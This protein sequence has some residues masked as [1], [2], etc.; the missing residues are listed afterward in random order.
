M[1]SLC[2][3]CLKCGSDRFRTR[4]TTLNALF[5]RAG[6]DRSGAAFQA[7]N[8]R[9]IH[10]EKNTFLRS[11]RGLRRRAPSCSTMRA[12]QSASRSIP[13][14]QIYPK[15]GWVEHDPREIASSQLGVITEV[16]V[17]SGV[18][19]EE[20]DSIGITNQRET[21]VVWNRGRALPLRMPS[22]GNAAVRPISSRK[23]ARGRVFASLFKQKRASFPMRTSRR[24]KIKW[25]LD[26]VP[27]AREAAEAGKLAFGTVDTWLIWQLTGGAVHATDVTNAS[28]TMLFNIHT[29]EWDEELL[30]LF[31]VPA[32]LLPEVRPSSGDFWNNGLRRGACWHSDSRR[33]GRSAGGLVRP[34]L[35]RSRSR[36]E[37]VW[38][39]LFYV[40]PY[41][42]YR[43]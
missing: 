12:S 30:E 15:P 38:H 25:L 33:C 29:G 36:Q 37:H 43:R 23:C 2:V 39:G 1:V 6:P 34:V 9:R 8:A 13:F 20:I 10:V 28:R 7:E 32:S 26:H 16:L 31:D 42:P 19:P 14:R 5:V 3:F 21:T 18:S 22:C 27:G 40:A 11:T 17:S 41:G 4:R 24:S 35:L